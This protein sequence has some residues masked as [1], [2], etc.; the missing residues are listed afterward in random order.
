MRIKADVPGRSNLWV[1]CL[2]CGT[3][4]NYRR[5]LAASAAPNA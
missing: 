4:L 5:W 2:I 1:H 3:R